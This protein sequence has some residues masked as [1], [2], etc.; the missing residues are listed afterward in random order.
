MPAELRVLR[1]IAVLT[2]ICR[3]AESVRSPPE[4]PGLIAASVSMTPLISRPDCT[5]SALSSAL[6]TPVVNDRL[7]PNG[8]PMA[9]P[10][11]PI[12]RPRAP[13]TGIGL[14]FAALFET[15]NTV[16]SRSGDLPTICADAASPVS[17]RTNTRFAPWIT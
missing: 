6:T 3:P 15:R 8:L 2:P 10:A 13:P 12:F 17:N 1:M 7:I 4:L 16:R 11:C 14:R 5:G 9:K